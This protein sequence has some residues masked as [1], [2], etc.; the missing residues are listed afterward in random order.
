MSNALKRKIDQIIYKNIEGVVV[1][2]GAIYTVKITDEILALFAEEKK[3]IVEEILK[4]QF[5]LVQGMEI[6]KTENVV[7]TKAISIIQ[8]EK[9]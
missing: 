8:E 6:K 3:R 9:E 2:K 7:P 5:T 1:S 4:Y